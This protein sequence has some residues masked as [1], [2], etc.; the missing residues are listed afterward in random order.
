MHRI[1]INPYQ[2]AE[3]S[4]AILCIVIGI[5]RATTVTQAKIQHAIWPKLQS[6]AIVVGEW[7]VHCQDDLLAL[8]VGDIR[9][10]SPCS[11]PDLT[12]S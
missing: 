4:T 8:R 9:L 3:Q 2:F 11:P 6:A 12:R 5:E 1:Y 7:L 10:S